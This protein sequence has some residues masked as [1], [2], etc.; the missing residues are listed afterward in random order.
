MFTGGA[1][2]FVAA[3]TVVLVAVA[4]AVPLIRAEY[5]ACVFCVSARA[6]PAPPANTTK[7]LI[8]SIAL[9]ERRII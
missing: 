1:V 7:T 8:V 5:G 6:K 3:G 9:D 2:V 4:A